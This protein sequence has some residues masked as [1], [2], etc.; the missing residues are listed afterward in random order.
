MSAKIDIVHVPYRG[1]APAVQD[2]IAG[3]IPVSTLILSSAVLAHHRAGR[4]RIL[5][6]NGET[7]LKAA[8]EVPTAIESGMPALRV[9]VFNAIFAPGGT[10][11]P[12]VDALHQATA[13]AKRE[14]S[15]PQDLERAGAEM[16]AD[17]GPD[18]AARFIRDEIARWTPIVKAS[19][20]RID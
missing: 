11:L 6:V 13:K 15:F 16:A 7:R 9:V 14:P 5:A 18:Q 10:P 19:G 1:A 8:P 3:H 12:V 17:S 4:I 20:F 2:L